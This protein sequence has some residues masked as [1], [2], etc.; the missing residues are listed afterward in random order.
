MVLNQWQIIFHLIL[1]IEA[2]DV[3]H[4]ILI[5]RYGV[6]IFADTALVGVVAV[7]GL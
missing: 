2:L 5:E 4:L 6:D 3:F 7:I 1:G